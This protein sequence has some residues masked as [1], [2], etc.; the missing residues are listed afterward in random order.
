MRMV[1]GRTAVVSLGIAAA[2]LVSAP[3]AAMAEHRTF[4]NAAVAVDFGFRGIPR[5]LP[6][7]TYDTR[8]INIG[9]APHVLVNINLGQSCGDLTE[10]E[11]IEVFD[12]GEEAFGENCPD[13]SF[14]GQVFAFGGE[15]ARDTFTLTPGR[16]V[17]A[18][19]VGRH[20]ARGMISFTNVINVG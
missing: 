18:C 10:A 8:F 6:A 11:L 14:G 2:A 1:R 7:G 5:T 4:S 13:A 19:F 15:R 20:Y 3:T 17:F 9:Q 12:K 16:N